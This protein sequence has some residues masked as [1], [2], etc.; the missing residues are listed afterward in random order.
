MRYLL[1][2]VILCSALLTHAEQT[3]QRAYLL[4]TAGGARAVVCGNVPGPVTELTATRDVGDVDIAWTAAARARTYLVEVSADHGE[5]W[6]AL[7]TTSGTTATDTITE[8][9]VKYYRVTASNGL[10]AGVSQMEIV[11]YQESGPTGLLA[12]EDVQYLGWYD[13][14][15]AGGWSHGFAIRRVGSDVRFLIHTYAA[16]N[17]GPITEYSFAGRSFGGGLWGDHITNQWSITGSRLYTRNDCH[18]AMWWDH[19]HDRLWYLQS[20]DYPTTADPYY[21][22]IHIVPLVNGQ[23]S[24]GTAYKVSLENIRDRK[25]HG[26]VMTVPASFQSA[27]GWPEFLVG[28]GGYA[29][30]MTAQGTASMGLACYAMPDPAAYQAS[31]PTTMVVETVAGAIIPTSAYKTLS[32]RTVDDRGMRKYYG[33]DFTP[34]G[35]YEAGQPTGTFSTVAGNPVRGPINYYDGGDYRG[36]NPSYTPHARPLTGSAPYYN[37]NGAIQYDTQNWSVGDQVCPFVWGDQYVGGFFSERGLCVVASLSCARTYYLQSAVITEQYIAELHVFDLADLAEVTAGTRLKTQ[38]Q[39][40]VIIPL[41]ET[42]DNFGKFHFD[43]YAASFDPVAK[44]LYVIA[45][46]GEVSPSVERP[47]RIWVYQIND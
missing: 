40:K 37:Y 18:D 3:T 2:I 26:G 8:G 7:T 21:S 5:T 24:I 25:H 23:S 41:S 9:Q 42:A 43:K 17:R 38:V 35:N 36:E 29:S 13:L 19:D 14:Y 47:F 1:A 20:I 4:P 16:E 11:N 22:S 10:G 33:Y 6:S 30:L 32:E 27:Y 12:A 31:A 44:K 15:N 34:D 46:R 28:F 39:P 45:S